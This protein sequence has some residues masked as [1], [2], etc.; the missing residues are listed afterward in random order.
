[1]RIPWLGIA[2]AGLLISSCS[3]D[4]VNNPSSNNTTTNNSTNNSTN[5]STNNATNTSTNNSTNTS[6]NNATNTST[7]N[8]TNTCLALDPALGA[9]DPICQTGCDAAD[10]CIAK[11]TSATDPPVAACGV[12]GDKTSGACANDTECGK[13]FVCL[14]VE[15][16]DAAC[17]EYCRP[18]APSQTGCGAG[19]DCRPFQLELRV[20]VCV[21]SNDQCGFFPDSCGDG[22]NCYNTPNGTRCAS[23]ASEAVADMTCANSNECNDQYRCVG[24][25]AGALA[26]KPICNPNEPVCGSGTCQRMSD[27]DGLPLA[28]GACL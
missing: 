20:G 10:H 14:S 6:T 21:A 8:S 2:V 11:Q 22:K 4:D 7:N 9:C 15:G 13:G 17:L 27:A 23:F 19:L 12:A 3:D 16:A 28:W 25:G 26:C 5:T 1:M 24:V 18:G